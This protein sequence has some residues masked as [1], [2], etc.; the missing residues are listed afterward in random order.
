MHRLPT[1]KRI[2]VFLQVTKDILGRNCHSSYF[3][4][5]SNVPNFCGEMA[6]SFLSS[7]WVELFE[8]WE[9][10]EEALLPADGHGLDVRLRT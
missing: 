1:Y 6:S 4:A 5:E 8:W 9:G 10:V 7:G 3:V 2:H